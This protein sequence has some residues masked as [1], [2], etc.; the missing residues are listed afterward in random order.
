MTFLEATS[1]V[2]WLHRD[3]F[4][5]SALMGG[6]WLECPC[7]V[8][9]LM[10]LVCFDLMN[11]RYCVC[12]HLVSNCFSQCGLM[13]KFW[14]LLLYISVYVSLIA[15]QV[16]TFTR[17]WKLQNWFCFLCGLVVD[18][19]LKYSAICTTKQFQWFQMRLSFFVIMLVLSLLC[20]GAF[21]IV[22][23]FV[24]V[25]AL[26]LWQLCHCG[27]FVIVVALP[28]HM[29]YFFYKLAWWRLSDSCCIFVMVNYWWLCPDLFGVV[30]ASW[31]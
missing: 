16:F 28:C 21:V 12:A 9:L 17:H 19:W 20:V 27:S 22:S 2:M 29:V 30:V 8:M 15:T 24:I 13:Y 11:Q 26:S 10:H 7:W 4:V 25:V 23:G 6:L 14:S 5:I 1:F 18:I 3:C 31:W